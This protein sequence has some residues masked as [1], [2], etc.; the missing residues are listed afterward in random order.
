VQ[1]EE[2]EAGPTTLSAKQER[3][4]ILQSP[5]FHRQQGFSKDKVRA[6]NTQFCAVRRDR[7]SYRRGACWLEG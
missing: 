7:M 1:V 4:R 5:N 6:Q 2:E 3:R